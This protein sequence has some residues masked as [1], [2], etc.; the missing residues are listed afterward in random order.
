LEAEGLSDGAIEHALAARD[1]ERATRLIGGRYEGLWRQGEWRSLK[2]WLAALP[3]AVIRRDAR[4]S[5]ALANLH[6]YEFCPTE[7]ERVLSQA[8]FELPAGVPE[9]EELNGRLLTMRAWTAR[10]RGDRERATTL[11]RQACDVLPRESRD[12]RSAALLSLGLLRGA[13]GE[14]AAAAS[15]FAEALRDAEGGNHPS[16]WL[17]AS[18]ALGQ[19]REAEG[20]LSEAVRI[21]EDGIQCAAD[22][23]M[24]HTPYAA[25]LYSGLGRV[26]Y[27]RNALSAGAGYLDEALQHGAPSFGD[28]LPVYAVHC[29]FDAIRV[30]KALGEEPEELVLRLTALARA[31]PEAGLEP[32]VALLRVRQPAADAGAWL[33]DYEAR[34][35]REGWPEL[36]V[37]DFRLP[38]LRAL[39]MVTWAQLRLADVARAKARIGSAVEDEAT[40]PVRARL[41][42]CLERMEGEG[43]RGGALGVRLTL[44]DLAWQ[45]GRREGSLSLL[46]PAL[47]LAAREG[48]VRPFLDAGPRLVPALRQ[49]VAQGITPEVASKLLASSQGAPSGRGPVPSAAATP[50]PL[51]EALSER[52]L[53]VL[54]LL[55][56]GLSNKEIASQL[57]LSVGTVKQHLHHINGKLEATSRTSAVARARTLGL[58]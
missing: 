21:Y 19:L 44:V 18:N 8:E 48:Y 52:E 12:L 22:R 33:A 39:E 49:A 45:A 47:L 5:L 31:R 41:E 54:R 34:S 51:N 17:M 26:A 6:N 50:P 11:A 27:E 55:A 56:A 25:L 2:G 53:E 24:L 38:D 15:L 20:A 28:T 46:E 23:A 32:L 4:L 14:L 7:A 36:A 35:G 9:T 58:L 29:L 10:M 43:R 42:R 1:W 57:F 40:A 37:P 30:R 3:P 16:L 13:G